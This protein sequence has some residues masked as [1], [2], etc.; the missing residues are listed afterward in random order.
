VETSG[1]RTVSNK[2]TAKKGPLQTKKNGFHNNNNVNYVN[3]C[4]YFNN[5]NRWNYVTAPR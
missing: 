2:G 4:I 1:R 5:V 3:N